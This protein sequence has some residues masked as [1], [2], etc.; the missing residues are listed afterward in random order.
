MNSEE[1]MNMLLQKI[2][3]PESFELLYK[4]K[5]DEGMFVLFQDNSGFRHAFF[6][7][8]T[9]YW[10]PSANTEINP[11]DGF[12]WGMTNDPNISISTFAGVIT[13][14]QI[15][16]VIIRQMNSVKQAKIIQT[17]QGRFWFLIINKLD[18]SILNIEALSS[19]DNIIWKDGVYDGK[20]YRGVTENYSVNY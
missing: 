20:Y 12:T 15:Q 8:K 4:E 10:N 14:N 18:P 1:K 13:N 17:E 11:R 2:R 19:E 7:N 16:K 9:G 6:S 3:N 5:V